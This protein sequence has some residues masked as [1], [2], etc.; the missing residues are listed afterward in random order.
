[1]GVIG[2]WKTKDGHP[3]TYNYSE[4][5]QDNIIYNLIIHNTPPWM[6]I[7]ICFIKTLL[8][9]NPMGKNS[10]EG[11]IVQHPFMS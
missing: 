1:M 11:K 5:L 9:K 8:E 7:R 3:L 10:S 2:R 6:S 4:Q